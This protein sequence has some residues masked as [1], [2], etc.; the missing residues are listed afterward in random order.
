MSGSGD[1]ARHFG[2]NVRRVRRE[3]GIS[4]EELGSR[5]G[6]HRTEVGLLERG[7]RVP[8]IDTLLKLAAGLGVRVECPLFDGIVWKAGTTTTLPGSFA[9]PEPEELIERAAALRARQPE[10]SDAVGLVREG[11]E[12]LDR[13]GAGEGEES[14]DV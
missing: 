1:L 8:R 12:E 14:A 9:F 3:A 7:A 6:L 10:E 2:A 4:Q 11:R 13:R 5:S